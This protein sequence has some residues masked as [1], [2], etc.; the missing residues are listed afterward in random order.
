MKALVSAKYR[1]VLVKLTL[2]SV[3]G[4]AINGI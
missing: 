4:D 2:T 1:L 3:N